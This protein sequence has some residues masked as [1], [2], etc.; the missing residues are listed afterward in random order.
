MPPKIKVM[1]TEELTIRL[2][3]K[4]VLFSFQLYKNPVPQNIAATKKARLLIKDAMIKPINVVII[5]RT[6]ICDGL[7]LPEGKG[8]WGALILSD[9]ISK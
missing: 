3:G 2:P 7:I 1:A 5:N 6:I 4:P 9:S 8:R